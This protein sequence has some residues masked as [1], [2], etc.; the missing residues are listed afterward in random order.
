MAHPEIGNSTFP[1]SDI[2]GGDRLFGGWH[3][4]A[5]LVGLFADGALLMSNPIQLDLFEDSLED[6]GK[7]LEALFTK[8]SVDHRNRFDEALQVAWKRRFIVAIVSCSRNFVMHPVETTM[9]VYGK[10]ASTHDF[11]VGWKS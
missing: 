11:E 1:S 8:L 9:K 5:D 6:K 3:S 10:T 7:V 4:A 2:A